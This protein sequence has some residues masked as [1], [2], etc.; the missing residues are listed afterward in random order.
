M[1]EVGLLSKELSDSLGFTDDEVRTAIDNLVSLNL[2]FSEGGLMQIHSLVK[3][4]FSIN[5]F[6]SKDWKFIAEKVGENARLSIVTADAQSEEFVR[7][8]SIAYKLLTLAGDK[9]VVDEFGAYFISGIKSASLSLFYAK[10]YSLSLKYANICL[11]VNNEDSSMRFIKARCLTR[12]KRYPEAE[13]ELDRLSKLRFPQHKVFHAKG[14]LKK[15]QNQWDEAIEYFKL[16]LEIKPENLA[17]LRD[18]GDALDIKGELEESLKVLEKSHNIS[19]FDK[20]IIPKYTLVLS[21]LGS[22]QDALDII[23]KAIDANPGEASFEHRLST[24]LCDLGK[25]SEGYVHAQRAVELDDT[26]YEGVLHL[27]S[28]EIRLGNLPDAEGL[29][30][31]VPDDNIPERMRIAKSNIWASYYLKQNK[32]DDARSYIKKRDIFHDSYTAYLAARIEL[33]NAIYIRPTSRVISYEKL[34]R[35]KEIISTAQKYSEEIYR[36]K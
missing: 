31:R 14:L 36:Y 10:E 19:P 4:Y 3:D 33:N 34:M 26:F 8:F 9:K 7:L 5:A 21:K 24:I 30:E 2:V 23:N 25:Y 28:L 1:T 29:L 13:D 22:S 12:L 6:K 15:D 27:A 18:L 32:F 11:N 16:G 35:A 17:L 20:F